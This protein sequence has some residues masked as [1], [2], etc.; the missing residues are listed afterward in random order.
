VPPSAGGTSAELD[1]LS[2]RLYDRMR[3]QLKAELRLDRERAGMM[4]DLA[5]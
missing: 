3:Y 1:E 5:G 2:R 4:T